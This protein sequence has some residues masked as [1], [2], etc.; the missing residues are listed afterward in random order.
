MRTTL[1]LYFFD[2]SKPAEAKA[3]SELAESLIQQGLQDFHTWA[4]DWRRSHYGMF[5]AVKP[6]VSVELETEHLFSDQWNT[7][8]IP[9]LDSPTGYRVF[10]WASDVVE[11][12]NIRCGHYLT[13]TQE[14][15]DIRRNTVACGYC[16]YQ[17]L[18]RAKA[19]PFCPRCLDSEYLK[20]SDLRLTRMQAIDRV[21]TR[22]E[23]TEAEAA[24]LLP[25]YR[26]AQLKGTTVRGIARIAKQ[27]ADL[28]K[29]YETTITAATEEKDGMF[30]LMDHGVSLSNVIYYTHTQ[31]FGF[32]WRSP[33]DPEL[34]SQL[35]NIISEFRWPYEIKCADGRTL[36]ST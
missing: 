31:K 12:H 15:R 34:L 35:L 14:M 6:S 25:L 18:T 4:P 23:L 16:G 10:D 33:V 19:I 24:Y 32:G 36:S 30:W 1:N 13:Q 7:A 17:E 2:V 28:I 29:K 21:E 26:E 5:E 27:R 9:G 20:S 3:Y 8:P 22:P 11:N